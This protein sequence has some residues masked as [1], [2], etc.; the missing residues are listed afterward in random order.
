MNLFIYAY[1]RSGSLL[2]LFTC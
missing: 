1:R 2:L